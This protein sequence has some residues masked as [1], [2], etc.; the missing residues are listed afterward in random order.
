MMLYKILFVIFS[1]SILSS[2]SQ[3]YLTEQLRIEG[4]SH[5][6][7][8]VTSDVQSA[9]R[10]NVYTEGG[11]LFVTSRILVVDF[12]TDRIPAHLISGQILQLFLSICCCLVFLL[13]VALS[14]KLGPDRRQYY[15]V[16]TISFVL[17]SS[18]VM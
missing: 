14:S 10:Y 8:T 15:F 3:E 12:L 5:L 7:R 6:P 17:F 11:V 13:L 18:I 16:T 4:V 9:E 1:L 2:L